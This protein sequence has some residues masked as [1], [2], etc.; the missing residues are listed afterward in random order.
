MKIV[1]SKTRLEMAVKNICRVI[2]P[3]NALPILG[4]VLCMV[5]EPRKTI[6]MTG[7]DSEIWLTYQVELEECEGG[8]SFCVGADLLRD[9]LAE[10][11]AAADD[12]RHD[13]ERHEVPPTA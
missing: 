6:T 10:K 12:P 4:D 8:G 1:I 11:G 5:D 9:A 2:N 13:G 3:K 7:S